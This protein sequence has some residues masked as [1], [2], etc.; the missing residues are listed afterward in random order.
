[1][2]SAGRAARRTEPLIRYLES[3]RGRLHLTL[4]EG[5]YSARLYDQLEG[6]VAKLVVCDPRRNALLREG[7]RTDHHDARKLATLTLSLWKKGG[8]YRAEGVKQA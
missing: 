4:E 5:K 8:R 6:R 1:M 7:N 3:L 2:A